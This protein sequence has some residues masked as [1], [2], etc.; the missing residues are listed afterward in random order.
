MQEVVR[1]ER[2][3]QPR[4]CLNDWD[5]HQ[6]SPDKKTFCNIN[7]QISEGLTRGWRTEGV[8]VLVAQMPHHLCRATLVALHCVALF[9]LRS[10]SAARESRN[11]P[12][13]VSKRPCRTRLGGGCRT[14]TLH[15]IDHK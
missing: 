14:S 5:D 12:S 10:R 3:L 15:S 4:L 9:A 6:A 11:T 13:S 1:Q 2:M 8:G 7:P